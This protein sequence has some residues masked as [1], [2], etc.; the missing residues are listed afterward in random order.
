MNKVFSSVL[1]LVVGLY[2]YNRVTDG[3]SD[4]FSKRN[5][6]KMRKRVM[7]NFS[8]VHVFFYLIKTIV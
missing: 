5:M 1:A 8:F 7:K 4:L 3:Q 6:K 2:A